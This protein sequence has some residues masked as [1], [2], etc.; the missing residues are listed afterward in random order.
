MSTT[1]VR[2]ER[3][4]S[5][6]AQT[7]VVIL[8]V[9]AVVLSTAVG[10]ATERRTAVAVSAARWALGLMLYAL[11]PFVSFVN[12]SHLRLSVGG[13]LGLGLAYLALGVAGTA[14]W[15]IGRRRLR[16]PSPSVGALVLSVILVNTGYLGLPMSFALLGAHGFGSAVAY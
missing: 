15:A 6:I 11:L 4:F 14:A 13:S 12:F 3:K 5:L 8:V 7:G 16:L 1:A 10:V 9:L 2:M